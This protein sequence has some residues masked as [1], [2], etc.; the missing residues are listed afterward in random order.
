MTLDITVEYRESARR[1][2]TQ[3]ERACIVLLQSELDIALGFLRLADVETDSGKAAHADEL[4]AKANSSYKAVLNGLATVP[5]E[6][7]EE[8][9]LLREGVRMLQDAIRAVAW[10]R[11]GGPAYNSLDKRTNS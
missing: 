5:V 3:V 6:F 9:Q 8:K 2:G 1:R 11:H 7:A 4:I 10:R